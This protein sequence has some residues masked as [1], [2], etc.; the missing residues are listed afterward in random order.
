MKVVLE[1]H[2]DER[3]SEAYNKKLGLDRAEAVK[4]ELI[5]QGIPADQLSTVTFGE[6]RPLYQEKEEWA[7]AAN[8]RVEMHPED[9]AGVKRSK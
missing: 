3:G 9:A 2:T 8:R 1:G 6:G 5:A 7:Y 4:A